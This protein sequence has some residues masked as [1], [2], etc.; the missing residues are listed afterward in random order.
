MPLSEFGPDIQKRFGYDEAKAKA[1]IAEQARQQAEAA[2]AE[3]AK[4]EQQAKQGAEVR[5]RVQ[6]IAHYLDD[7][8]H[9]AIDPRTGQIYDPEIERLVDHKCSRTCSVT[10]DLTLV[11]ARA[12]FSLFKT[13]K[14][15]RSARQKSSHQVAPV[16][17]S[18]RRR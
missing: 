7:G 11:T 10:A 14:V 15:N 3:E 16:S 6:A 9:V 18:L 8:G 13:T 1:W 2:K 12:N 4:R 17:R 5:R